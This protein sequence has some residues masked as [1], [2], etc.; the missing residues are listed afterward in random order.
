MRWMT[1]TIAATLMSAL[2]ATSAWAQGGSAQAETLYRQGRE[3]MAQKKYAEACAAFASSHKL[4]ATA[5]TLFSHAVC[6]EAAGDL[7]TAWG[8]FV[9]VERG[10]RSSADP[11]AQEL[12]RNA[13][14][15]AKKL[16]PRLSRLKIDV[17]T[18][19]R[20]AGIEIRRGGESIDVGA[21]G[22]ALPLDGGSYEIAVTAPGHAPWSQTIVIAGESDAKTVTVPRLEA[23]ATPHVE[24]AQP[25]PQEPQRIDTP[26]RSRLVPLLFAG[27]A[28][29]LGGGALGFELWGRGL[30]DDA[31]H[32]LDGGD[33]TRADSLYDDAN[34][35][36]YVATALGIAAL[37]SAGVAIYLFVRK[38]DTASAGDAR[39][40]RV[41]PDLSTE[42]VGFTL[43]AGW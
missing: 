39:T 23:Q 28:V 42:R 34:K 12:A 32:A 36:R 33:R 26:P 20:V 30:H 1:Q 3:L 16:E 6:R 25:D 27:G 17:P 29:V 8:L 10:Y 7:A 24:P 19:H 38:P 5:T 4:D 2:L 15:R 21:W 40:V 31:Q 35:R 13:S 22:L 9:D 11:I 41:M 43:A 18:E 37:G 14:E